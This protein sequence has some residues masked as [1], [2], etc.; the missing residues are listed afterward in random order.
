[1]RGACTSTY[2]TS[3]YTFQQRGS[4][5]HYYETFQ[6]FQPLNRAKDDLAKTDAGLD[7][8]AYLYAGFTA[9]QAKD[10]AI[11]SGYLT[12]LKRERKM[13]PPFNI[14]WLDRSCWVSLVG[15][16]LLLYA[17]E[18]E[19]RPHLVVPLRGYKSRPAPSALARDPKR[20]EAAFEIY[21][22]G[23][24]T[25]QFVA[26]TPQE[27]NDWVE[28]VSQSLE[29]EAEVSG[30]PRIPTFVEI[31]ELESN[32]RMCIEKVKEEKEKY[33]DGLNAPK[34]LLR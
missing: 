13:F 10:K 6:D 20:S 32:E 27:M 33:Q 2:L 14:F 19:S 29:P 24:R 5:Q 4:L 8:L 26:K 30:K 18:R 16:H 28:I 31:L 7:N 22:P 25:F 9:A 21:C 34:V 3:L 1:M 23:D 15:S 17:N 11:K 12:H